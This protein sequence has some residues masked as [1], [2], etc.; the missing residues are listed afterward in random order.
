MTNRT[1][2]KKY[3]IVI[4]EDHRILREGLK[5]MLSSNPAYE[6]A[7]EGENGLEAIRKTDKFMPDLLLIDLSMPKMDG[8]DA[9]RE[10][11]SRCPDTRILVLTVHKAEEYVFAALKAGASGYL[12]KDA[13]HSE[14]RLAVDHVL[15]GKTYLS[16]GVSEKLVEYYL[17]GKKQMDSE[18]GLDMLTQ[19]ERQ[20][21]KLIAEGNKN[22]GI[23]DD[24]CISIKTVEKHRSNLMKKLDMHNASELTAF[25]L[26][27]GLVR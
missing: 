8:L 1:G 14:L 10:I 7:G 21:L 26:Q 15:N 4:V 16:P 18:F 9:I 11:R 22:K 5:A 6:I 24:L 3:R 13:T 2:P 27:K 23:A 17:D 19:R 20:I 12:L 25:A